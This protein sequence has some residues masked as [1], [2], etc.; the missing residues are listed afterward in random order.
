MLLQNDMGG[1]RSLVNKWTT[2]LKARLICAVPGVNGIDTHFDE[3]RKCVFILF[4]CVFVRCDLTSELHLHTLF[5]SLFR[6][7][8]SHELQG[9]KESSY[10]RRIHHIQVQ[11]FA[12]DLQSEHA[13]VSN[14][15]T[16]WQMLVVSELFCWCVAKRS[17]RLDYFNGQPFCIG[18]ILCIWKTRAS[19]FFSRSLSFLLLYPAPLSVIS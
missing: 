18:F 7:R 4:I 9:P 12:L 16:A 10:L 11:S 1:H 19:Y 5:F 2:F 15:Q 13:R 3:L 17:E 14:V 6:G 8:V